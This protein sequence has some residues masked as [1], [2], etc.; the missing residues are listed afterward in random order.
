MSRME[1]RCAIVK[2]FLPPPGRNSAVRVSN[3]C[4]LVDKSA[5]MVGKPIRE[6]ISIG[7]DFG[8]E[9]YWGRVEMDCMSRPVE[10]KS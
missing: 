7:A 2:N 1:Q 3:K 8:F 6:P 9:V 5:D 4:S 10:K